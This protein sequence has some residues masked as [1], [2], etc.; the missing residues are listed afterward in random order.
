MDIVLS[1]LT[2]SLWNIWVQYRQIKTVKQLFPDHKM[3]S[4]MVITL[5]SIV[6]LGLYFI[7]HEYS[8]TRFLH[9]K[10]EGRRIVWIEVSAGVLTLLGLWFL[11]DSYQQ[12]SINQILDNRYGQEQLFSQ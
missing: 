7:Y 4:I 10:T 5:L 9:I 11:V 6:T 1:L 3:P 8:L 2:F 12:D